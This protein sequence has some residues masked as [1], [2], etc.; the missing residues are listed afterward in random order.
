MGR[1]IA[2]IRSE[3]YYGI[4][5]LGTPSQYF[6]ILFDTGSIPLWIPS[7][8]CIDSCGCLI[9]NR[10]ES[11]N[12]NTTYFNGKNNWFYFQY[13]TGIVSGHLINDILQIAGKIVE[14]QQ[15]GE[16]FFESNPLLETAA[17]DGIFGL[18]LKLNNLNISSPLINIWKQNLI[19]K[20]LFSFYINRNTSTLIKGELNIGGYNTN[21]YKGDIHYH[22]LTGDSF[23]TI[24]IDF[25]FIGR[26]K[27]C[28]N[29]CNA[30]IDTGS[31]PS[32]NTIEP[33]HIDCKK[34]KYLP[35]INFII[36]SKTYQLNGKDYVGKPKEIN[37]AM[38]PYITETK[39]SI[40]QL[41]FH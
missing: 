41:T 16:I 40:L 32:I 5:G 33:L 13:G 21:F 28:N 39:T 34:I 8:N 38:H 3:L 7:I 24:E 9:H 26:L 1:M 22:N 29:K 27:F 4:I 37:I 30:M 35:S 18:S 36:D 2:R 6:K 11:N 25:G 23:W 20:P 15:F 10:F 17:Y 19:E 12:S 14:N 31:Y